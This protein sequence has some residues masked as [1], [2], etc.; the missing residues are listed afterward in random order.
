MQSLDSPS[1]ALYFSVLD[2]PIKRAHSVLK[3]LEHQRALYQS[4]PQLT[5]CLSQKRCQIQLG[6]R[7]EASYVLGLQIDPAPFTDPG[8]KT[9]DY[10]LSAY[11]LETHVEKQTAQKEATCTA[12]DDT[13][14]LK[15]VD[16]LI[17]DLFDK[18]WKPV[19]EVEIK[20]TPGAAIY[21]DDVLRGKT[22]ARLWFLPGTHAIELRRPYF[23][24]VRENFEVSEDTAGFPQRFERTLQ[25]LP[26][27][28]GEKATRIAAWITGGVGL[29]A[30]AVGIGLLLRPDDVVAPTAAANGVVAM[31]GYLNSTFNPGLGL[32]V[33]G[34]AFLV[35]A[36]TM[37]AVDGYRRAQRKAH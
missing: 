5:A 18:G 20:S 36:I 13:A 6:K 21:S 2:S 17:G 22:P 16:K 4:N 8:P 26:I 12:C 37:A 23:T 32:A 14:L 29:A 7:A 27:S 31:P 24:S 25:P 10:R 1:V 3:P 33:T 28:P 35:A 30:T 9:M 11:L 15:V 19:R 34:G